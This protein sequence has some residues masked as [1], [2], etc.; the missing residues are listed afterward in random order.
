MSLSF[1]FDDIGETDITVEYYYIPAVPAKLYGL[2]ENCSPSEAAEVEIQAIFDM[3][4]N[5]II[6]SP[7]DFDALT[8][9]VCDA[10]ED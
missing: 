1:D 7:R 3:D 10:H 6:A 5:D 8:D 4:D 2:P 9:V